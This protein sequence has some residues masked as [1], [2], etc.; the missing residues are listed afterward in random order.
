MACCGR[1]V[2]AAERKMAP[3]TYTCQCVQMPPNSTKSYNTIA[4]YCNAKNCVQ[5]MRKS[6]RNLYTLGTHPKGSQC[7]AGA[8]FKPLRIVVALGRGHPRPLR[9]TAPRF[10]CPHGINHRDRYGTE[11]PGY[12]ANAAR[13]REATTV[14][15]A[16]VRS[17]RVAL[18]PDSHCR[19]KSL[20]AVVPTFDYGIL[21]RSR[22]DLIRFVSARHR[23]LGPSR[24]VARHASPALQ[25]PCAGRA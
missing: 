4:S 21:F 22:I 14:D 16:R 8:S 15:S 13:E 17:A 20:L 23:P 2:A 19:A 10:T 3:R 25:P 5:P 1:A 9:R 18:V 11:A 7:N 6:H 12:R 24:G